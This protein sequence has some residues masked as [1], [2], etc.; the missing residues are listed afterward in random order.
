MSTW[1]GSHLEITIPFSAQ[2]IISSVLQS[3]TEEVS[4]LTPGTWWLRAIWKRSQRNGELYFAHVLPLI[5]IFLQSPT[6]HLSQIS[7]L[8]ISVL[9]EKEYGKVLSAM[10]YC[11]LVSS[12]AMVIKNML[13][14]YYSS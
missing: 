13:M 3:Q 12:S 10:F 2:E 5:M 1:V 11:Q 6:S 7:C 14:T 9:Y 4:L 8:E